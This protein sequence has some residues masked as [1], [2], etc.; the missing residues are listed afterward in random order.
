MYSHRGAEYSYT[1]CGS[2]L[3]LHELWVPAPLRGSGIGKEV[4]LLLEQVDGIKQIRIH[5]ALDSAKGFYKS[6]GYNNQMVKTL[7][8]ITC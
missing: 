8:E 7:K 2:T 3:T 6:C 1:V 5:L 4:M